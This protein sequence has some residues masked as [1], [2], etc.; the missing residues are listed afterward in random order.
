MTHNRDDLIKALDYLS[1]VLAWAEV[2]IQQAP[3]G[4]TV[5]D[6]NSAGIT[7]RAAL[8]SCLDDG[9]AKPS[10]HSEVYEMAMASLLSCYATRTHDDL[11]PCATSIATKVNNK[12]GGNYRSTPTPPEKGQP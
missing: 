8:Q 6:L 2:G 10:I 12:F 5:P 4:K 11:H 7:I 1:D 3:R 9:C